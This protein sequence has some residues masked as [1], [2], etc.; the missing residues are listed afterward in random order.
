LG[1]ERDFSM[2]TLKPCFIC[3]REILMLPWFQCKSGK[4]CFL[5]LR[6]VTS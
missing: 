6:T 5:L 4:S 1:K 2:M 3:W